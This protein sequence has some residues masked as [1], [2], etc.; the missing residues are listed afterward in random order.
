MLIQP[1]EITNIQIRVQGNPY[2][3]DTKPTY[4]AEVV[5][6]TCSP[7]LD[8][9]YSLMHTRYTAHSRHDALKAVMASL[10][11][12]LG[13]SVLDHLTITV[14]HQGDSMKDLAYYEGA[15]IKRPSLSEIRD[16]KLKA[17]DDVP[18][19]RAER[20]RQRIQIM[21]DAK[22]EYEEALRSYCD[23]HR[24]RMER[25]W[26]DARNEYHYADFSDEVVRY[27]EN[28]AYEDGHADGLENVLIH[29]AELADLCKLVRKSV[30]EAKS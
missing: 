6:V 22:S 18:L 24:D 11:F 19:T 4:T 15:D 17:L 20:D 7:Y 16:P 3:T 23:T 14:C 1:G 30:L 2:T 28:K 12:N 27:I 8:Y 25:F 29:L 9:Q 26:Q 5:S 10:E 21:A 13:R